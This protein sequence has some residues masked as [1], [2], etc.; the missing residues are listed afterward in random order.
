MMLCKIGPSGKTYAH[1]TYVG[2][3]PLQEKLKLVRSV[4]PSLGLVLSRVPSHVSMDQIVFLYTGIGPRTTVRS[5]SIDPTEFRAHMVSETRAR[6]KNNS[7]A[8]EQSDIT[9]WVDSERWDYIGQMAT[10]NGFW[11]ISDAT[12]SPAK[13]KKPTG[14]SKALASLGA[15]LAAPLS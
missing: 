3:L 1:I 2:R 9:H 11:A 7:V 4:A 14:F 5:I 13:Q 15:R 12:Q 10:K 8:I 6:H